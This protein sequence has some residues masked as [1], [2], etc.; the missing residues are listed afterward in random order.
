MDSSTRPDDNPVAAAIDRLADALRGAGHRHALIGG[1]ACNLYVVPRLSWD[2][3]VLVEGDTNAM[4]SLAMALGRRG[5]AIAPLPTDEALAA[6][7][8]RLR[9][10][11][12]GLQIDLH[13]ARTDFEREVLARARYLDDSLPL[14]VAT[15]EDLAVMKLVA[16]R[17]NDRRDLPKLAG[18][19]GFDWG[20]VE[21]WARTWQ[22]EGRLQRLRQGTIS[23]Q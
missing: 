16:Y 19:D 7:F 3:D 13:P 20:Y 14:P 4:E 23:L 18:L 9:Y 21:G 17:Y 6:D 1:L 15:P 12:N 5:F 10:E 11:P 8:V 22:V 2:L